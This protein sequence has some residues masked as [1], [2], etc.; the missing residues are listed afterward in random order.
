MTAVS[1]SN[2]GSK[3]NDHEEVS[4]FVQGSAAWVSQIQALRGGL[5]AG[6]GAAPRL[7]WGEPG[8]SYQRLGGWLLV[9]LAQLPRKRLRLRTPRGRSTAATAGAGGNAP[10]NKKKKGKGR[11]KSFG[12]KQKPKKPEPDILSPVAMLNLYYIAHNVADCLYLRGYTWPGAPK[13]KRGKS[14]I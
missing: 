12:K 8:P 14:K 2:S 11:V 7:E 10:S 6:C 5:S 4:G 9:E 13:G 3:V 1:S